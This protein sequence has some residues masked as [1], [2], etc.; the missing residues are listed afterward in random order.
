MSAANRVALI[1][2]IT[3]WFERAARPLPWRGSPPGHR[4]GYAALVSEAM[5]QQ[6]QVSRVVEKYTQFMARFP[7][8]AV[9][10]AADAGDVAAAWAGLGYYRRARNLHTA[11][12]QVVSDFEGVVPRDLDD[13]RTLAGVGPYTAGAIASIAYNQPAAIVDGNVSR[14]LLRINGRPGAPDDP[15]TAAWVWEEAGRLAIAAGSGVGTFNES[16]MELGATVCTPGASPLC[17]Q[18]PAAW[19]CAARREGTQAAIPA[20]KTKAKSTELHWPTLLLLDGSGRMLVERRPEKGLWAGLWQTP[21]LEV[22]RRGAPGAD[23]AGLAVQDWLENTSRRGPL[24]GVK[25]KRGKSLTRVLTHR[26]ITFT[27]YAGKVSSAAAAKL[28][29]HAASIGP[30]VAASVGG[31]RRWEVPGAVAGLGISNAQGAILDAGQGLDA[32]GGM[33]RSLKQA[34][35]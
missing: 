13:L 19:C 28:V 16:L 24:R 23:T 18:C 25:L 8:I 35:G 15:A 31:E 27:V 17:E 10:A 32:G 4:D 34:R 33:S 11:A 7:T 6:T 14:V 1:S 21:T 9:L 20:P 26:K 29:K 30:D 5:L 3:D 12:K 22:P 2:A